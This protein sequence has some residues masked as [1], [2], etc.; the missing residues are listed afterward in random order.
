MCEPTTIALGAAALAGGAVLSSAMA[1]KTPSVAPT[2]PVQPPTKQGEKAPDA[3]QLRRK[4]GGNL[5]D[6]GPGA[7]SGST[8][9][10]GPGGIDSEGLS[11]NKNT[12]L[13]G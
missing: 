2:A 4:N 11:L 3:D 8:L 9:L 7:S 13:G 6:T 1:P 5:I 12:L 10:T